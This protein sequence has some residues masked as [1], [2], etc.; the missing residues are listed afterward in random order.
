[1]CARLSSRR[2]AV[3]EALEDGRF[4][5]SP[6]TRA[7]RA[8]FPQEIRLQLT[9]I[10]GKIIA[11]Q[12]RLHIAQGV[13]KERLEL[14]IRKFEEEKNAILANL[15]LDCAPLEGA[16]DSFSLVVN[17]AGTAFVPRGIPLH[18]IPRGVA[19]LRIRPSPRTP[20]CCD[21]QVPRAAAW[22]RQSLGQCTKERPIPTAA[23]R[24]RARSRSL[25]A[26]HH[27]AARPS[28]TA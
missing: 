9:C 15:K 3:S 4:G 25:R 6:A 7:C 1:V 17:S 14:K 27:R 28:R 16:D 13:A 18:G 24:Q 5:R 22:A 10:S 21:G 19:S 26:L 11:S 2:L 12:A 20:E 23:A 8:P